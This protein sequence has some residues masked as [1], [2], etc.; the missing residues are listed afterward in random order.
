MIFSHPPKMPLQSKKTNQIVLGVKESSNSFKFF[1]ADST[2]TVLSSIG[3]I[4]V[5]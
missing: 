5:P 1:V 3:N 2:G 4:N